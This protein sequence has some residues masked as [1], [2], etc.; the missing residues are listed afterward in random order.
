[1]ILGSF[2]FALMGIL[3]HEAGNSFDWQA[4]AI[5]RCA[6]PLAI[7]ALLGWLAG[8][9]FVFLRPR[10]LW[11]RSIAGSFSLVG[12]FFAL[13]RLPV[14]DVF[15]V[16]NIFPVWVAL[17]SWLLLGEGPS[18]QVWTSVVCGVAGVAIIQQPHLASG[19]YAILIALAVSVFTATAMIGLHRL[20]GI[21]TRAVVVHFSSVSLCFALAAYFLL[22]HEQQR[23]EPKLS[24]WALLAG[25]GIAA[26]IGQVFLTKAFTHGDPA[27]VSVVGLTQIVFALI[28]DAVVLGHPPELY[29]LLGAPL[30]IAPTAWLLLH[31]PAPADRPEPEPLETPAPE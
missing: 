13:T 7:V 23:A 14:A 11:M 10:V 22:D 27:K 18:L 3:A 6:V 4:V 30:V 25:I 31:K 16:T 21:D 19:N 8:I 1:M 12:T 2:S 24:G 26:T 20:K 28:L 5:A 9:R 17:F 15:T 29:K